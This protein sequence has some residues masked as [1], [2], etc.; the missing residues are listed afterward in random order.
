VVTQEERSK[1]GKRKNGSFRFITE[2]G[3]PDWLI[4]TTPLYFLV[5]IVREL[6]LQKE[7][8]QN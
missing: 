6:W 7:G 8:L 1:R 5:Y 4:H 2:E 3:T